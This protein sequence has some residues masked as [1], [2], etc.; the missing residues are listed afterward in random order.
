MTVLRVLRNRLPWHVRVRDSYHRTR[1][2]TWCSSCDMIIGSIAYARKGNGSVCKRR[3]VTDCSTRRR[4]CESGRACGACWE[5]SLAVPELAGTTLSSAAFIATGCTRL[6]PWIG[7]WAGPDRLSGLIGGVG[8]GASS[9]RS[10][11]NVASGESIGVHYHV[12]QTCPFT[13][14]Y[15]WKSTKFWWRW[16]VSIDFSN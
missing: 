5:P 14:V 1:S 7:S 16:E 12:Q 3:V 9:P 13:L 8:V 2:T 10:P 15:R 11:A 6:C 4:L